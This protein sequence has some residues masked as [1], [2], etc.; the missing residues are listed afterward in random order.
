ARGDMVAFVDADHEIDPGWAESA[1]ETLSGPGVGAVGA[2]YHA[3]RDGTWV[4][5]VYD[6]LRTRVPGCQDASWLG[7]GNLA[8]RAEAFR[9][10]QGFDPTLET[11]EDVDLCQRLRAAGYR[12]MSDHRLRSVH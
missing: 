6:T 3:P 9:R 4:Q 11:C 8:V 5:Q 12:V 2:P 1:A 10:V 7:S